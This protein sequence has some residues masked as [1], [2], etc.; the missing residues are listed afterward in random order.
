[1]KPS[2]LVLYLKFI[3]I[4]EYLNGNGTGTEAVEDKNHY[5]L[6]IVRNKKL[7]CVYLLQPS[8]V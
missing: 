8:N 5:K 7:G 4:E 3:T 2:E 6:N 1:M